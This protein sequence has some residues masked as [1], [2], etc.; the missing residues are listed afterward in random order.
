MAREIQ[1]EVLYGSWPNQIGVVR[2]ARL[3]GD[4]AEI[5][6]RR[7]TGIRVYRGNDVVHTMDKAGALSIYHGLGYVLSLIG[8]ET[9]DAELERKISAALEAAQPTPEGVPV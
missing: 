8:T 4:L 2:E 3:S 9:D 6:S 7:I 1:N 5:K